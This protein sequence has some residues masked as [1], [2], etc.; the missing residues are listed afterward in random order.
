TENQ[1]GGGAV[2]LNGGTISYNGTGG[3][4]LTKALTLGPAGGTY[5]ITNSGTNGGGAK[6]T[7]AASIISGPGSITLTGN[8]I[9]SI[10]AAQTAYQGTMWMVN[11]GTLEVAAAQAATV[12][13]PTG[14]ATNSI[15]ANGL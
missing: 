8:G 10:T 11:G 5:N 6:V 12:P 14:S 13:P 15:A 4:N 7:V 9:L 2:T 1:L 3:I